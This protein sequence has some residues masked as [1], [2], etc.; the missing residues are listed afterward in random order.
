MSSTQPDGVTPAEREQLAGHKGAVVW[1]TGLS[2]A[3]KTT[4]ARHLER[5]LHDLGVHTFVLDGDILRTGLTR[6]LGFSDADRNENLRRFTEVARLFAE[7][8]MVVLVSAITPFERARIEAR[9]R[10][11]ANRFVLV[12]MATPLEVCEARDVKGLYK[13]A[14]A[15]EIGSF[16]GL[17]SPYEEP[18]YADV[19]LG[20]ADGPPSEQ[21]VAVLEVLAERGIVKPTGAQR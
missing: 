2:G 6:D 12:H 3:G 9:D 1:F 5:A 15:G 17:T 21:I 20:P 4:V 19:R 11:G 13:K 7:A 8:G 14:R 10:V 18:I 16:T